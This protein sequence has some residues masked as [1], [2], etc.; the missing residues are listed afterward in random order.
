M[1]KRM[2][3]E[4]ILGYERIWNTLGSREKELLQALKADR[5][6]VDYWK[7]QTALKNKAMDTQSS[8]I[9]ELEDEA[10]AGYEAGWHALRL[11][12]DNLKAQLEAVKDDNKQLRNALELFP[13]AV[14][15]L[16]IIT[17]LQAQL[18]AVNTIVTRLE[19]LP[20]ET[21]YSRGIA[22]EFRKAIGE[23]DE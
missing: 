1:S 20:Q 18:E 16:D 4:R 14:E 17:E 3:D 2:T 12:R 7:E 23:G 8:R 5:E 13:E 22:Y 6:E 10:H 21:L 9:T 15:Q 11:E 19:S